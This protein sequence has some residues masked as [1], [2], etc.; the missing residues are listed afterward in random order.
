[1]LMTAKVAEGLVATAVNNAGVVRARGIEVAD[2]GIYLRGSG[3]S[4]VN[5]GTLDAS[6]AQGGTI[7][8]T[9]TQDVEITS[10]A[11]V[12]ATG[13]GQGGDVRLVA[14]QNLRVE[15]GAL[16]DT[17]S[18]TP[19]TG[20]TIELSAHEGT[21]KVDGD[22][23]TGDGGELIIDPARVRIDAGAGGIGSDGGVTTIRESFIETQL[24]YGG[25][26]LVASDEIFSSA[27]QASPITINSTATNSLLLRIGT[28]GLFG[29]SFIADADGSINLQHVNF[30]LGGEFIAEA[31][32]QSGGVSLGN[33]TANGQIAVRG[34]STS[35][36]LNLGALAVSNTNFAEIDVNGAQSITITGP[37]SAT[38]GPNGDARVN[39]RNSQGGGVGNILIN[40]NVSAVAGS[41]AEIDI[42]N[43]GGA[44]T[45]NGALSA[46][47]N[48]ASA[49]SG[50]ASI[51][52]YAFTDISL[53]GPVSVTALDNVANSFIGSAGLYLT[54]DRDIFVNGNVTVSA[55]S[56]ADFYTSA[57]RDI[58]LNGAVNLTG[59]GSASMS[60]FGGRN[61]TVNGAIN[62]VA[63][64]N[65]GS[66]S[67]EIFVDGNLALNN[68]VSLSA[69]RG[70]ASIDLNADGNLS[71]NGPLTVSGGS[72]ADASFYAGGNVA[73]NGAVRVTA[74]NSAYAGFEG[75]GGITLNALLSVNGGSYAS[76][77]FGAGGAL[78]VNG[79]INV[80]APNGSAYAYLHGGSVTVRNAVSATGASSAM[81]Y[82]YAG[83][84]PLQTLDSGIFTAPE[85]Y[86][87]AGGAGAFINVRTNASEIGVSNY[88][89]AAIDVALDN[90][91]NAGPTSVHVNSYFGSGS[92]G[93][94]FG[95]S[96]LVGVQ[97]AYGGLG[98]L[99]ARFTGDVEVNGPLFA[100][101]AM[102][103]VTNGRL[104]FNDTVLIGDLNLPPTEG[105]A[106]AILALSNARRPDG[107]APG[108]PL[109]NGVP[110][111]G[112]NAIF[113][114]RNGISFS[115]GLGFYD[116][117][118]PYVVFRTDGTL[119]LGDGVFSEYAGGDFLAQFTSYTPGA[120]IYVENSMPAV[121]LSGGP[122]FTNLEHFMKLP[123]TTMI[124][125]NAPV[126]GDVPTGNV[127][128]GGNGQLNIGDQN[129]LFVA[130][131]TITGVGNVLSTGFIGELDLVADDIGG[132]EIP[133]INDILTQ[134]VD[135]RQREQ[136]DD[137]DDEYVDVGEEGGDE[138]NQLITQKSDNGQMC[139]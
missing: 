34:G 66:A 74:G 106:L 18:E 22:I 21:L 58:V 61:M 10:G 15:S 108:L 136:D 25:F 24:N 80:S 115:S 120:T 135:N 130:A 107:T 98:A 85:L 93:S 31:G 110:T 88:G 94:S 60:A 81:V 32:F 128:I 131:G 78:D 118:T 89:S 121:P 7:R 26:T 9:S 62:L 116:P 12:S 3:G 38:S 83:N 72:S 123:G 69:A 124:I 65:Y 104:H 114:A 126:G 44:V 68:A 5:S 129:I 132:F 33:V 39:I 29:S 8:V 47:Q 84:G 14:Q 17:R 52:L 13:V 90:S 73:V 40:G 51:D 36:N 57:G 55:P 137:D 42:D 127:L 59:G 111:T 113:E 87:A 109:F 133:V 117:D 100:R 45:V 122:T 77:S 27:T 86:L 134:L 138:S 92:Y 97:S 6:G 46:T 43:F 16:V 35:G 48:N 102:I 2:G 82:A 71:V 19:G 79:A 41:N 23:R 4:V 103:E 105:D 54:A 63:T 67:M 1:V 125:G 49:V 53:N 11:T 28:G 139:Q 119:D 37:A 30:N 75:S 101:N 95:G 70:G 50:S 64:G 96:S 56:G 91:A 99:K 20:G 76:A 112:A